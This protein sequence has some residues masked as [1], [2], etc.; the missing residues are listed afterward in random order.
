MTA[1]ITTCSDLPATSCPAPA[2]K[3]LSMAEWQARDRSRRRHLNARATVA[4]VAALI[5]AATG[6]GVVDLPEWVKA[7][8]L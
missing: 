2:E 7:V 6:F 8:L 1:R 3:P 4:V 5:V